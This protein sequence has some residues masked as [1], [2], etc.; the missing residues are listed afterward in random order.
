MLFMISSSYILSNFLDG[1]CCI[2]CP[3]IFFL[4]FFFFSCRRR[5]LKDDELEDCSRSLDKNKVKRRFSG[6]RAVRLRR[7]AN[8]DYSR[9]H[10]NQRWDYIPHA[11]HSHVYH[12]D[13]I[14]PSRVRYPSISSSFVGLGSLQRSSRVESSE[15]LRYSSRELTLN[16]RRN[17]SLPE[18]RKRKEGRARE[19]G[20]IV[21]QP[22]RRRN[23][24]LTVRLSFLSLT[25]LPQI[26][27]SLPSA[28]EYHS[29][30]HL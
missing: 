20:G 25:S 1:S 13:S 22:T 11:T 17:Y 2:G 14:A 21:Q 5:C 12:I 19:G 9:R 24:L 30:F 7:N 15:W 6:I 16:R 10:T 27:S 23:R 3:I 8:F 26:S 29:E 4:L 18:A 28:F